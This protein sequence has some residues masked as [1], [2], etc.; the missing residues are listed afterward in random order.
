MS[1]LATLI[2]I[3]GLLPMAFVS[4]LMSLCMWPIPVIAS[5]AMFVSLLV[6]FVV[7]PWFCQPCYRPG[8][9][10]HGIDEEG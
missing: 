5:I 4:G 10:M 7:I 2:V 9:T 6:M 8:V 3:A 1:R